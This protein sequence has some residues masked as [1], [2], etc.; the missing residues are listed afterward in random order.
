MHFLTMPPKGLQLNSDM[1][2]EKQAVAGLFVT[3]LVELGMCSWAPGDHP[4]L[5]NVPLFV[6]S[7]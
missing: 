5:L 4:V 1:D 3:E 6:E 7:K 2:E